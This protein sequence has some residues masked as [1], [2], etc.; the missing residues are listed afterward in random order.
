MYFPLH[1]LRFIPRGS[2]QGGF[3]CGAADRQLDVGPIN[4]GQARHTGVSAAAVVV[5]PS[6]YVTTP[7]YDCY[8]PPSL[9]DGQTAVQVLWHTGVLAAAAAR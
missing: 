9:Y 2:L 8:V 4:V 6:D 1:I 3:L 7:M 5:S